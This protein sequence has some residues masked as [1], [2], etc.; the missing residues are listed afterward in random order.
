L[1]KVKITPKQ[2]RNEFFSV[3]DDGTLKIR[4]KAIPEK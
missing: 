3:L 1:V 2:P 4:I